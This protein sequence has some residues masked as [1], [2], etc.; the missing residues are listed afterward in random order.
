MAFHLVDI[1]GDMIF[2]AAEA[3]AF[4][5]ANGCMPSPH[6]LMNRVLLKGKSSSS[7]ASGGDANAGA[8]SPKS[9]AA[10]AAAAEES[11]EDDDADDA[12]NAGG[13]A[14]AVKR[15]SLTDRLPTLDRTQTLAASS[16]RHARVRDE[17][18]RE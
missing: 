17:A 8:L 14:D 9:A 7:S 4:E 18:R 15:L 12:D 1:L 16:L 6:Q 11:E 2:T 13:A 3:R 5:A 10:A